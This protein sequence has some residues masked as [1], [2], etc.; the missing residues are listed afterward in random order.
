MVN[1]SEYMDQENGVFN[2]RLP[3]LTS[4]LCAATRP[5]AGLSPQLVSTAD[6]LLISAVR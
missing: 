1:G 3:V 6:R 5:S 2:M 4:A